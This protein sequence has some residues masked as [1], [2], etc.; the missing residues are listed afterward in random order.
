MVLTDPTRPFAASIAALARLTGPVEPVSVVTKQSSSSSYVAIVL[1]IVEGKVARKDVVVPGG[2]PGVVDEDD[3]ASIVL[4]AFRGTTRAFDGKMRELR[5]RTI[6]SLRTSVTSE[7]KGSEG[8]NPPLGRGVVGWSSRLLGARSLVRVL[9]RRVRRE[10]NVEDDSYEFRFLVVLDTRRRTVRDSRHARRRVRR[11]GKGR[12]DRSDA[13][14]DGGVLVSGHARRPVPRE[15]ETSRSR[16]RPPFARRPL[17]SPRGWGTI[18]D[19]NTVDTATSREFVSRLMRAYAPLRSSDDAGW[20]DGL[21]G[22][23]WDSVAGPLVWL[24]LTLGEED[25]VRVANTHGGEVERFARI[26]LRAPWTRT[27]NEC[28]AYAGTCVPLG[29]T[30]PFVETEAGHDDSLRAWKTSLGLRSFAGWHHA[31]VSDCTWACAASQSGEIGRDVRPRQG[32]PLSRDS[33][34]RMQEGIL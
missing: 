27:R 26:V 25:L 34:V 21:T 29:V 15:G 7:S 4:S 2:G 31:D 24:A 14:L 23:R 28:D 32:V 22:E 5:S 13:T 11:R 3:L 33:P 8:G 6:S 16:P 20:S 1:S 9:R 10:Q 17:A 19:V 12:G 18:Q 30:T